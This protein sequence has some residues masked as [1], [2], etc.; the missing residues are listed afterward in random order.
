MTD[1]KIGE[2]FEEMEYEEMALD[3]FDV[4]GQFITNTFTA[5]L[6]ACPVIT[7]FP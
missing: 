4:D 5:T 7:I 2:S 1:Y 6:S 3:H